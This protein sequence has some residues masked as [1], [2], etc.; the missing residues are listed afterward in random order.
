V[1]KKYFPSIH[2]CHC[3]YDHND[4]FVSSN[5]IHADLL[6]SFKEITVCRAPEGEKK[7]VIL[8]CDWRIP[9]A[10]CL[11]IIGIFIYLFIYIYFWLSETEFHCAVEVGFEDMTI[12]PSSTWITSVCHCNQYT[13]LR[14]FQVKRTD[15]DNHLYVSLTALNFEFNSII[16]S[17]MAI[18]V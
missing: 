9:T 4:K 15:S 3:N 11:S 7:S 13:V 18:S 1:D 12:C 17:K 6:P 14:F 5:H 8:N 10:P 16:N 2:F